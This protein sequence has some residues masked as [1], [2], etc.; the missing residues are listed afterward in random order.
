M[1]TQQTAPG[2]EANFLVE[3]HS[4]GVIPH[5]ARHGRA[6][7]LFPLWFGANCQITIVLSGALAIYTGLSFTW[8]IVGVLIGLS[9]GGILMAFHSAQGPHLGLPQMIQSR[10]QF[11]FYGANLPLLIAIVMYL[12]FFA[13]GTVLAAEALNIL[14]GIAVEAAIPLVG[15][16]ILVLTIMGY[17]AIH[18]FQRFL[19]IAGIVGFIGLTIAVLA[20]AGDPE[21]AD[22]TVIGEEPGFVLGPFLLVVALCAILLLSYGPYVADYSRYLPSTTSVRSTFWYTF[23]AAVS[24]C[25]WLMLLGAAL[26]NRYPEMGVVAQIAHVS[27]LWVPGFGAVMMILI[28][29]GIVGN[30][31]LNAYGAFMSTATIGTSLRNR[32]VLPSRRFR[33]A[34]IA[35]IT[36]I[37]IVLA[38]FQKDA[39]LDNW[40]SL[41]GFLL[42]FLIPWTAVNL[43]D[44]YFVRKGHYA[45][46]QFSVRDGLYGRW[47]SAGLV[48]FTI[49][50]LSQFPFVVSA[51]YTGPL[52][53]LVD[54]GDISWIIGTVVAGA[55]YYLI[56]RKRGV[57]GV[58]RRL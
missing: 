44:Y 8:T 16:G 23:S 38:Y 10:A 51:Y 57:P 33:I 55:A 37:G 46:D 21:I 54:G 32:P 30:N 40:Q 28:V 24:A 5:E 20:T 9:L 56:A 53:V 13:A 7:G 26:Q 36:I 49:G 1:T 17:R 15:A 47:N 31:S 4:I 12:G 45:L 34:Y 39:L 18:V 19:T 58:E 43:V 48:A 11:G 6:R 52:A 42:Y 27:E 41:L 50:C 35:P 22:P 25:F 29:L 14:T 3:T 2:S